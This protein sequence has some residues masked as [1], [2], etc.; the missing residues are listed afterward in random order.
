MPNLLTI[1][2]TR[3]GARIMAGFGLITLLALLVALVSLANVSTVNRRLDETSRREREAAASLLRLELAV[4]RQFSSVQGFLL[5]SDAGYGGDRYLATFE[6]GTRLFD[7]T[8]DRLTSEID[9][10]EG[11]NLL[12]AIQAQ[13]GRFRDFAAQ[14]I[15]LSRQGFTRS[16]VYFWDTTGR[17]RQQELVSAIQDYAAWQERVLGQELANAR[18]Q[19]GV[20]NVVALSLV[21]LAGLVS[22]M[23]AL[24]LTR[25]ITRPIHVLARGA[26]QMKGGDLDA[27]VPELGSDEIGTLAQTMR[28]MA[29]SLKE[30][31]QSLEHSL[32]E[33]EQRNRELLARN[34]VAAAAASLDQQQLF[35]TTLTTLLDLTGAEAGGFHLR[36]ADGE[37]RP[38]AQIGL[39]EYFQ[40]PAV[41]EIIR[42][43]IQR[44]HHL[45]GP[46]L[47]VLDEETPEPSPLLAELRREGL[48]S[49][50]SAPL[51]SGG[52][53]VGALSLGSRTGRT[54]N[55]HDAALL[56]NIS[57]QIS[58]AVEN[59]A[60]LVQRAQRITTL[61][62]VNEVSQ[63][64]SAEL[65][66][67]HLYAV[68]HEQCQRQLDVPTF[69]IALWDEE[70]NGLAPALRFI[71]GRALPVVGERPSLEGLSAIVARTRQ[72][73]LTN[74]YYAT[75]ADHGLPPL[76]GEDVQVRRSW[77]GVPM[78][79]GERLIGVIIAST[80]NKWYSTEDRDLLAA[81][82]NQAAVA[83]ENASLYQETRQLG[84]IEER[85]RLAREIHDTI[86][87]GLTG[88]VLQLEATNALLETRP[89]RAQQRLVKATELAR[90]TLVEARRSVWNLRPKPLEERDLFDAVQ[91]EAQ[92]LAEDGIAVRCLQEGEA[93]PL[94][95]EAENGLYRIAQE[96]LQNIRK[97][98]R[99]RGVEVT[100]TWTPERL[101]LAIHDDGR[102]FDTAHLSQRRTDGG[103]FGLLSMRERARLVGGR[104][105]GV[106]DPRA[107]GRPHRHP[108]PHPAGHADL[109]PRPDPVGV[110]DTDQP[111]AGAK[112][113]AERKSIATV[114]AVS[115]VRSA[116]T[117]PMTAVNL[118]ACPEQPA[119]SATAGWPGCRSITKCP[120]GVLVYMQ[121]TVAVTGPAAPG[122]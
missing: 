90:N 62:I 87:Q 92:R 45:H 32:A 22:T 29:V 28:Q 21:A 88:I 60:L 23:I 111:R 16:P 108:A 9:Q 99:A 53:L 54:W 30:S 83:I 76:P 66:M 2:R 119:P 7:G 94:A 4:E 78:T 19:S 68:I 13:E 50:I 14:Q 104:G 33:T 74:D 49:V 8:L 26:T 67:D 57:S 39:T 79:I 107:G 51:I 31:R 24:V 105:D 25:S 65:D 103:G 84:I 10:P 44:L 42:A 89:E 80:P 17:E 106:D 34:G 36:E 113:R 101:T 114:G 121:V 64:I 97:H 109:D 15:A 35:H 96:A 117:S 85:N 38:V 27:H 1:F 52:H 81:I 63:A 47:V 70:D 58:I 37:L 102:G 5:Y 73:L 120:S 115:R 93:Q 59:A 82:A 11:L 122:M 98:A 41:L 75:R 116:S 100:L 46:N 3:I 18:V 69:T 43:E 95:P 118:K 20:V 77:L 71:D 55:D 12:A 56:A 40:Q 112:R 91:A 61:S 6:A 48:R 72:P 86:A 110:P